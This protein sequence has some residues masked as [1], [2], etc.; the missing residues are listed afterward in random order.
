MDYQNIIHAKEKLIDADIFNNQI[1][2]LVTDHELTLFYRIGQEIYH[3]HYG[4]IAKL[5]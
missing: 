4:L 3:K 5:N 2:K 1:K